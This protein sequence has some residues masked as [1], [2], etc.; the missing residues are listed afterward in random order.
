VKRLAFSDDMM[1]AIAA[2]Q[3]SMTRRPEKRAV[4][5]EN[6]HGKDSAIWEKAPGMMLLPGDDGWLKP[7]FKVDEFVAATCAYLPP[8][9]Y[10]QAVYR[11][12]DPAVAHKWNTSRIMPA[13]LSPF[14]LR[15][16]EVKAERLGDISDADAEREGAVWWAETIQGI[17]SDAVSPRACFG[18]LWNHVY[19]PG[20]FERNQNEWQWCLGFEIAE[21][22]LT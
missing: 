4:P 1:R 9:A 2:G 15:T 21:N 18:A 12:H 5:A 8:G 22:R 16:T 13:A 7:R 19:N 6:F 10:G 11:F 14:V 17:D 3:K 20:A